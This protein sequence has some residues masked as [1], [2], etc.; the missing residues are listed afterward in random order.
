MVNTK[1]T[2]PRGTESVNR[3]VRQY[4][5]VGVIS[6]QI[7]KGNGGQQG[8]SLRGSLPDKGDSKCQHPEVGLYLADLRNSKDEDRL[9]QS[10]EKKNSRKR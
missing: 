7:L 8:G 5:I 1:S 9:E 3:M 6:D 4:I 10:H 2:C